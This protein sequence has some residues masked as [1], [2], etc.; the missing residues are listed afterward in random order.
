MKEI[1]QEIKEF[2][3]EESAKER[4]NAI[5]SN[6]PNLKRQELETKLQV[7]DHKRWEIMIAA[8]RKCGPSPMPG[9]KWY[10]KTLV[11]AAIK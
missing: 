4:D 2:L 3:D 9:K 11:N 5:G 7:L 6:N 10:S 1:K 8:E